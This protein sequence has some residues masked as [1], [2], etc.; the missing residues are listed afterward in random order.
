MR[1][2]ETHIPNTTTTKP[3]SSACVPGGFSRPRWRS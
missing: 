1:T 2:D 3:R